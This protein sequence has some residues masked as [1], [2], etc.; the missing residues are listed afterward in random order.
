[1][2][3]ST[4]FYFRGSFN[5]GRQA[6]RAALGDFERARA[7]APSDVDPV[8]AA[9]LD[10][11]TCATLIAIEAF[12]RARLLCQ[13]AEK[14]F[15]SRGQ[16]GAGQAQLFLAQIEAKDDP[17][18][19]LAI[20]DRLLASGQD[21]LASF[22]SAPQAYRLRSDINR[23]L[24]RTRAAY[25]DLEVYVRANDQ[26]RASEQTRQSAVLRA[27]LDA[28]RS[29]AR[30]QELQ[31]SLA[32]AREREREQAKRYTVL[33]VSASIGV[34]LLLVILGMGIQHRRKLVQLANTDPLTGL[35][36]RRFI[37]EH[38]SAFVGD[39]A[40]TGRPL[41]VAILD[42]DHFKGLN[43]TYGHIVGDEVL[44]AFASL[45]HSVL[46]RGDV[47]ARWGGEE[48]IVVFPNTAQVKAVDSLQ[49]LQ[50]ALVSGIATSAGWCPSV[51]AQA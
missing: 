7:L 42:L 46:R 49:R 30:N 12:D 18:R 34:V 1:M 9:F 48:F 45:A 36:N 16:L 39:H 31:R 47:I 20:L 27:S 25:R 14:N 2:A 24:G 28:D 19:A 37:N 50:S 11:Q 8:G 5:L 3:L 10:L 35:H 15:S 21:A 41:S 33:S 51:L 38:E 22:A 26:Q 44:I 4:D 32:F 6:Y 29:A 13:Q 43:D 17:A 40:R 23:R